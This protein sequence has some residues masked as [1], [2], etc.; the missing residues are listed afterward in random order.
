[1]EDKE[2]NKRPCSLILYIDTTLNTEEILLSYVKQQPIESM[3]HQFKHN[4]G[5][6]EMWQQTQQVL[7]RVTNIQA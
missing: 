2:N 7:H 4:L 3:F 5:M 1:M 6:E